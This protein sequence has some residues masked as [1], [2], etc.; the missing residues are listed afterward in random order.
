LLAQADIAADLKA[1]RSAS[2]M[3]ITVACGELDSMT[4]AS[5]C[6][7]LAQAVDAQYVTLGDVGHLCALEASAVVNGLLGLTEVG[8]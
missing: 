2:R 7:A 3:P 5:A 4:P 6:R 1:V 8:A